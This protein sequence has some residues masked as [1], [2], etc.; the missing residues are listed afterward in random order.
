MISF[1]FL[2][3]SFTFFM[4]IFAAIFHTVFHR[5]IAIDKRVDMYLGGQADPVK[6]IKKQ[7]KFESPTLKRYWNLGINQVNKKANSKS[8]RKLAMMLRDAGYTKLTPAEFRLFQLLLSTGL[9]FTTFVLFTPLSD[10]PLFSWIMSLTIAYLGYRILLFQLAKKKTLRVKQINKDMADFFDMV[11]LLLEAGVGLEGAI[12]NVC[13]KTKGPLTE[14][15]KYTLEDMKRGKSR[16]EAFHELKLRVPSDSFQGVIM[17]II[18]ADHLGVGM[19]RVIKNLTTRIRE[20]R[21]EAAR[22]QA[23]K[24][25]VKMLIPMVMFIFPS[26]FIVI[27]GPLLVK[28]VTEGLG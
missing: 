12:S 13:S 9:G 1:V 2:I 27:L 10:K 23:M 28:L 25:P 14:E 17:S 8:Q 24:A 3:S 7:W 18:Q 4:L 21:R 20:Q 5:Q 6:K 19:A 11:N 22:E 16:R 15:F 26:L